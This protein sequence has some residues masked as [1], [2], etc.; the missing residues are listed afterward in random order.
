MPVCLGIP[1]EIVG[2]DADRPDRATVTVAGVRRVINIGLFESGDIRP[3]DWVLVHVGFAMAKIDEVEAAATLRM[4]QEIG[5]V[6]R[7]EIAAFQ[8]SERG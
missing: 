1:G 3:G 7:D 5:P 6:F 2:V 4:L 8:S